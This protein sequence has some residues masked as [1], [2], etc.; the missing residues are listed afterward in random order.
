[1]P[2]PP[3]GLPVLSSIRRVSHPATTISTSPP[4]SS[5]GAPATG[6][7]HTTEALSRSTAFTTVRRAVAGPPV[8]NRRPPRV[9]RVAG[10]HRP[11]V[12]ATS[13]TFDGEGVAPHTGPPSG[14]RHT[15]APV[16]RSSA[17]SSCGAMTTTSSLYSHTHGASPPTQS[18]RTR[19]SEACQA[20]STDAAGSAEGGVWDGD[21]SSGAGLASGVQPT[22]ATSATASSAAYERLIPSPPSS[23]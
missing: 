16:W 17:T 19:T 3:S 22:T 18:G 15:S 12:T 5:R 9:A 20:V 8:A 7:S 10:W 4:M 11:T 6:S 2:S 1:M 21:G 23:P 14:S 13:P